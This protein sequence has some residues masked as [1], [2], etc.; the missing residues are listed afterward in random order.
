MEKIIEKIKE[1]L[2]F[3]FALIIASV[4]KAFME[5]AREKSAFNKKYKTVIKKNWLGFESKEYHER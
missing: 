4:V 5:N 3:I 1:G 2:F